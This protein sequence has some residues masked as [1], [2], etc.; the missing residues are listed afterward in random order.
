MNVS[1]INILNTFSRTLLLKQ[2][3]LLFITT[4]SYAQDSSPSAE[5][6]LA[7]EQIMQIARYDA[8]DD[9]E[10]RSWIL[11]WGGTEFCSLFL[12]TG[13]SLVPDY[14]NRSKFIETLAII[15]IPAYLAYRK[16]VNIPVKRR[17]QISLENQHHQEIYLR[18]YIAATKQLRVLNTGLGISYF[19]LSFM[20]LKA[21]LPS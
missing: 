19:A 5:N 14:K 4:P 10:Y 2:V 21:L 1:G 9:F 11:K 18:E 3:I 16:Q 12:I 7:T 6:K 20:L 13:T 17:N 15:G 8:I